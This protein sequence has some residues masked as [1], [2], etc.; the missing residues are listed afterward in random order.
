MPIKLTVEP[1]SN[2]GPLN[3]SG[4]GLTVSGTTSDFSR[5]GIGFVVSCIRLREFYLVGEGRTLN[6]EISLPNGVVRMKILGT[7]Y[8]QTGK[9]LSVTQYLIGA[10]IVKI[11]DKDLETYEEFLSGKRER[12]GALHLE[13]EKS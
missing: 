11:A 5:S 6:A 7:R 2:T 10:K 8:E 12:G 9:H 4:K 1:D 13:V 3:A